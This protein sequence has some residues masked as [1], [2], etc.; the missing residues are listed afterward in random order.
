MASTSAYAAYGVNVL[1]DAR[2]PLIRKNHAQTQ[3]RI[4]WQ[5]TRV[6][7]TNG[8]RQVILIASAF[9]MNPVQ[10][11]MAFMD[12]SFITQSSSHPSA[13]SRRSTAGGGRFNWRSG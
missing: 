6:G 7:G 3:Q 10:R 2:H 12:G 9:T 5:L 4:K 8:H 13:H 1:S 11:D